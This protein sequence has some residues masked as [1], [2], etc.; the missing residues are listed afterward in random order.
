MESPLQ[1]AANDLSGYLI[2]RNLTVATA[3]SCTGG[4]VTWTLC[5]TEHTADFHSCGYVTYSDYAKKQLLGVASETL[6]KYTAVSQ[7]TVEEMACGARTRSQQDISLAISGYAGPDGG[8]DGTPPGT[9]WFAWVLPDG[10]VVTQKK[11]F[12]G[13]CKIVIEDAATW[14]MRELIHLLEETFHHQG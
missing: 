8:K 3:E 14:A 4:L 10:K 13:H 7:Q 12:S 2:S 11:I 1:R 6:E 5:S 9:I